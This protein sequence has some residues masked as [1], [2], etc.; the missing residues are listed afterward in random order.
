MLFSYTDNPSRHLRG[1]QCCFSRVADVETE[2]EEHLCLPVMPWLVRG[3]EIRTQRLL[4]PPQRKHYD[5]F[6]LGRMIPLGSISLELEPDQIV[7]A[8]P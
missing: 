1:G 4:L 5:W 8:K 6:S 3:S 2:T 7:Q